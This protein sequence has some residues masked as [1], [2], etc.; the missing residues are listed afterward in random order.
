MLLRVLARQT[1]P[2]DATE[3]QPPHAGLIRGAA[4]SYRHKLRRSYPLDA[5]AYLGCLLCRP[6]ISLPLQRQ[7]VAGAGTQGFGQSQIHVGT[8][9]GMAVQYTGEH[10]AA[11]TQ[12]RG[13]GRHA[14]AQ[15]IKPASQQLAGMGG[16]VHFH[17]VPLSGNPGSPT[18]QRLCQQTGN[19][20]ANWLAR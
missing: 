16:V 3:S 11:N 19:S 12:V 15:V 7:P 4:K 14:C 8:D 17:D 10:H 13:K 1:T 2:P 9:G 20:N 5:L 6:Q 18:I